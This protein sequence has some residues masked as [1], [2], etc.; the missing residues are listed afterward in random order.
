MVDMRRRHL[1]T[2]LHEQTHHALLNCAGASTQYIG[3]VLISTETG[4]TSSTWINRTNEQEPKPSPKK[5][6]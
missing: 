1:Q 5:G 6:S 3:L 4:H 2:K